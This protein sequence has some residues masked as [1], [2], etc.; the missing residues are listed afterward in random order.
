MLAALLLASL[1]Y[2][3]R[4]NRRLEQIRAGK[5]EFEKM[6]AE[7]SRSTTQAS[8]TLEDLKTA[9]ISIGRDLTTATNRAAVLANSQERTSE[10]L[11]M[12]ISRGDA[13]ADRIQTLISMSRG[14]VAALN[15][16]PAR[17]VDEPLKHEDRSESAE[18]PQMQAVL[19]SISG[20]R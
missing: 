3:W 6:I 14:S 12:L 11:R 5:A 4:V 1:V 2:M 7:F 9:A 20:L 16:P 19:P 10:D 8:Q 13:L 17:A 18:V 15:L